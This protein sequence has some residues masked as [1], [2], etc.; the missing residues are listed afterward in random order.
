MK[1]GHFDGPDS[2]PK[3]KKHRRV[4]FCIGLLLWALMLVFV[5]HWWQIRTMP[6]TEAVVNSVIADLKNHRVYVRYEVDG[7]S[8][9]SIHGG[10]RKLKVGDRVTIAYDPDFP[11]HIYPGDDT[12]RYIIV[13]FFLFGLI[14]IFNS[15]YPQQ[16]IRA[17]AAREKERK[18]SKDRQEPWEI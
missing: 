5:F 16:A 17:L 15:R 1:N 9:T 12:L 8:Y 14:W 11:E 18:A 6:T 3:V 7:Q 10:S 4:Y 2:P 13:F